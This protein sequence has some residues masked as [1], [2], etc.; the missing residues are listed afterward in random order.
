MSIMSG[1]GLGDLEEV[2]SS[3]KKNKKNLKVLSKRHNMAPLEYAVRS[4]QIEIAEYMIKFMQDNNM[5]YL[6]NT[7]D[8]RMMM[9]AIK[10]VQMGKMLLSNGFTLED[11]QSGSII[12]NL[13]DS[14]WQDPMDLIQ[15][16]VDNGA[17][18]NKGSSTEWSP[19]MQAA[20][21]NQLEVMEYLVSK[22]ADIEYIDWNG[23]SILGLITQYKTIEKFISFGPEL[24][25]EDLDNLANDKPELLL[26]HPKFNDY[27]DK[28]LSLGYT[29]ILPEDVKD[30]F[31]F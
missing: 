25:D 22:G 27:I 29:D 4:D 16:V 8:G 17:D 18:V 11:E 6:D 24:S 23:T 12:K 9:S 26:K 3:I 13:L 10:S 30:I 5:E 1:I 14:S 7:I 31:I 21:A 20:S 15:F 2:K 28:L 19:L